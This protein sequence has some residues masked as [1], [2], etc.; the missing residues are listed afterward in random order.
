MRFAHQNDHGRSYT[1]HF[2]DISQTGL[3]FVTDADHAPH[4]SELIKIEVP[5]S[6]K[7]SI[8][9]WGRV[10]R[11]EEYAP[12]K[13]YMKDKDFQDGNQ[14][15]VAITF[16]ELPTGHAQIIRETLD[17][18]FKE[19]H[20]LRQRE[21]FRQLTLF[22]VHHFWQVLFYVSCITAT[23]WILYYLSR[24]SENYD[25]EKGAPWGERFPSLMIKP[26]KNEK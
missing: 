13:W 24:P 7:D 25:A 26:D 19:L 23:F 15:L 16:H 22:L 20:A 6:E 5:L 21:R 3:A 11:I 8:A 2:I 18:K 1:T 9:W 14:I 17:K 12:H 4:L 10:V